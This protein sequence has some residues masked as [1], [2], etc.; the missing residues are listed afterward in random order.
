MTIFGNK[1]KAMKNFRTEIKWVVLFSIASIFWIA[2][3]KIIGLHDLYISKQ[4]LISYFFTVPTILLYVLA[5]REKK[6]VFY[7]GQ[8]SWQ[9]GMVSGVYLS[10]GIAILSVLVQIASFKIVSPIFFDNMIKH[11]VTTK[12]MTTEAATDYFNLMSYCKQSIFGSLSVGVV[13]SAIVAYFVQ[14]KKQNPT[15][16]KN[17]ILSL[18]TIM[19]ISVS[20]VSTRNTI[21][22]IDNNAP[23]LVLLPTNVFEIK[24][25]SKNKKYGFDKD[26]PINIF[27]QQTTNDTINQPRFLNAL[28][29]PNGEKLVYKKLENCCPFPSKRTVSG[30]GFLDVYEISWTGN[31][32]PL[33]IYVNI[34]EKGHVFAPMG[35]S[36]KN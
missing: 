22:N 32:K 27:Y 29:G 18:V 16:M 2:A 21:K 28:A 3:E 17:Y 20:C 23:D 25:V 14:T 35:L 24:Q 19:F 11:M 13:L 36:I 9:Q 4:L 10:F 30:A 26:Y 7:K 8:I 6:S 31:K 33:K 12:T 5:I 15:E 1:F 34:Y